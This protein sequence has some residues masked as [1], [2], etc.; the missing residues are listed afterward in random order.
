MTREILYFLVFFYPLYDDFFHSCPNAR[1]AS[2]SERGQWYTK[3]WTEIYL[4]KA[5][6]RLQK[7][8]HGLELNIEDVYIMQ[9]LCPYE[10]VALGYSKFCELFTEE[11]WEGFNYA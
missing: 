4:D 11:E 7:R 9:Q 5:K 2:K 1:S 6:N 8:L 3:R 10:T